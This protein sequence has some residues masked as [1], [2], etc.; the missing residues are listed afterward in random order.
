MSIHQY[1]MGVVGNCSY[2]AYIDTHAEVKWMCMPRFDS[3]FLFGSLL[4]PV[5]GGTFSI[6]PTEE[7]KSRQY[8]ISNTNVLA[9]EFITPTGKFRVLDCAPRFLHYERNFKPLMLIRKIE[10]L[11]G[12][13]SVIV[14]C[15]PRG[16]YGEVMPDTVIGSNHL[17]FMN[18]E[19]QARLTTDISLSYIIDPQP[20]VL[21][22][23][24]YLVFTYGQPLEAPLKSTA[25]D[26]INK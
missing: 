18:L 7:F 20:F 1:N 23:S 15:Q 9:T 16:M 17:S 25:E 6:T 13:P 11:E 4:D 8:Y 21:D 3:S 24:R 5:K 26:F 10:L 2:I 12:G 14:K 22:Q 19:M